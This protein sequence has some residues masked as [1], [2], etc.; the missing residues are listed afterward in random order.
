MRQ[1]IFLVNGPKRSVQF[2]QLLEKYMK[3]TFLLFHENVLKSTNAE[4]VSLKR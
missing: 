3:L 2:N 4:I 1:I